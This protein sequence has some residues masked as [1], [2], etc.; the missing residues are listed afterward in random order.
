MRPRKGVGV[1]VEAF[2]RLPAELPIYLLLVGNMRSDR[3][4]A[5][6]AANPNAQR[7]RKVGFRKDAPAI[8][9]ACDV[10]VLP[11]LRREGLPRSVIEAMAYAVAP[12]VTDAGGSPELVEHGD[13]GIVVPPGD[14]QALG[15]AILRLYEE[16]GLRNRM[17]Q[18]ARERIA[19]HFH[20]DATVSSTLALYRELVRDSRT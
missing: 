11:T 4:D 3:L 8:V 18:R 6:I 17:G 19:T 9:A 12:I 13:S 20:V 10:S 16:P 2:A 15:D 14:R 7:I 5:A 1:L